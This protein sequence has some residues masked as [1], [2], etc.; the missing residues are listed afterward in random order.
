MSHNL[1]P[2]KKDNMKLENQV[3]NIEQSKKLK[4]LLKNYETNFFWVEL[5]EGNHLATKKN[6]DD[7]L[8]F[9][10][11]MGDNMVA[12][13]RIAEAWKSIHPTFTGTELGN[14]LP[15][16]IQDKVHIPGYLHQIR[17]T[18]EFYLEYITNIKDAPE[19]NYRYTILKGVNEADARAKMLIYLLENNLVD[20]EACNKR[21]AE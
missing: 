13:G 3:C 1:K 16:C 8:S 21:L 18:K 20:V 6:V 15:P 17:D 14:M 12:V 10:R 7:N 2:I 19:N 9:D 5:P 11:S 4:E